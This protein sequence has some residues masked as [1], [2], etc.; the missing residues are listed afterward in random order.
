MA[1]LLQEETYYSYDEYINFL[2]SIGDEARAELIFGEIYMMSSPS[3]KHQ[4][5]VLNIAYLLKQKRTQN[6]YPRLSPYDIKITINKDTNV[7]QPDVMLFCI[8]QIMP[9]AVFEVLS[10]STAIKDKGVKKELYLAAKIP[11]YYIINTELEIIDKYILQHNQYCYVK[12]FSPCKGE[13]I[14]I[15]CLQSDILVSDIFEHI[16]NCNEEKSIKEKNEN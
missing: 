9:C 14:H 13:M 10:P 6:C 12:G 11:E 2:K 5:I 3:A 16:K 15:D 4:D 1:A 7:V 8:D